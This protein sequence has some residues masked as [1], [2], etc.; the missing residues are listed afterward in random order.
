MTARQHTSLAMTMLLFAQILLAASCGGDAGTPGVTDAAP[1]DTTSAAPEEPSYQLPSGD[2]GGKTVNFFFWDR[3]TLA[4]TE[5]NGDVINDAMFRRNQKIEEMYNV[6]FAY[7]LRPGSVN[8]WANWIGTL[9]ASVLA[10][11]DA[12]QIGGGYGY[13]LALSSLDGSYQNLNEMPHIDFSQPWWPSNI[14]EAGN[15]GGALYMALG[16]IDTMYYDVTYVQYFNKV[17]AEEMKLPDL[18]QLVRDGKWTIDKLDSLCKDAAKDINGD[19]VMDTND[20]F[21]YVSLRNMEVDAF[22]DSCQVKITERDSDG[23][24]VLTGLTQHYVDVQQRV[25]SLLKQDYV[26]YAASDSVPTDDMFRSSQVLFTG[27]K[28]QKSHG[29]R[30][31]E[32]DF[33]ILPYPK[34]DEAQD[35]YR[36]YNALG[37]ATSIVVPITA[38]PEMMGCIV[39]ALAYLGWKD[40]LPEYYNKALKGKSARDDESGEMLDIIFDNIHFDFTQFYSY[41]F[42][43]QKAPSM[44]LRMS[45]KNDKEIASMWAADEAMYQATMEKLIAMLK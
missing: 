24:P 5:E 25:S 37:N 8:D 31:M 36:T 34:W 29:F 6:D 40:V 2:F 18:Y 20:R 10:G 11:D 23:M 21:G 3:T 33:G 38:D 16:N 13:R 44:L 32:T 19:T 12:I 26:M 41:T 15:L 43:D 30:D 27:D 42:G 1:G 22:L 7:D 35:G 28:L 14:N 4:A 39:E 45:I 17:L 9:S